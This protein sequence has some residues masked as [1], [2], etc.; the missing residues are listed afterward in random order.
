M[1]HPTAVVD[2]AAKLAADVE[3]G[4][5]SVIGAEVE[6]AEGTWVGPHVVI[7]GPTRI[8]RNNKIYQFASVGEDCQDK[9]YKGERTFLEIGDNNVIREFVTIQRGTVQD[10]SLTQIA[11][12]CLIM[13][14]THI[15]HD[16]VV[17]DNCVIANGT[18]LAGHVHLSNNV[19]IGGLSAIHQFCHV[20]SYV[21]IGGGT[22]IR[23]DVP[24]FV[25]AVG[26]PGVA[27]GMNYEGMKRNGLPKAVINQLRKAYKL[28]YQ[29]DLTV[30]KA[31][32]EMENWDFDSEHVNLFIES[33]KASSR[34]ILPE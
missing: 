26:N 5:Y 28:V 18:Q 17:G 3:V 13:N 9:K 24:A 20:G 32:E 31:I 16:C 14:Y 21:M 2:P 22:M 12:G 19:I 11:N 29:S 27:R 23:N 7:K 34:G 30:Q 15:A 25:M 1:I 6:I 33:I 8:G 10:N 4:P